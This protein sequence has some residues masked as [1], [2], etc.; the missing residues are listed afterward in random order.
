MSGKKDCCAVLPVEGYQQV[1]LLS[2]V[3]LNA[4]P[5]YEIT[6]VIWV[7]SIMANNA[8]FLGHKWIEKAYWERKLLLLKELESQVFKD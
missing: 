4:I 7:M 3:E 5:Y 8:E 2:S 1:R 6:G